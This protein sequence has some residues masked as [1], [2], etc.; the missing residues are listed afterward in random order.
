MSD[1]NVYDTEDP[2]DDGDS[3]QD[4]EERGRDYP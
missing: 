4:D 1:P 2:T 3:W